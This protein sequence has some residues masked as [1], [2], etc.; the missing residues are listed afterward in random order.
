MPFTHKDCYNFRDKFCTLY[1]VDVDPDGPVCPRFSAKRD[2]TARIR[3]AEAHTVSQQTL[4]MY[5]S[6]SPWQLWYGHNRRRFRGHHHGGHKT[7]WF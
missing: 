3:A 2:V 1:S 5:L 6:H 7:P 4:P